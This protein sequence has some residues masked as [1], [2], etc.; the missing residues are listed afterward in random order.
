MI[1]GL[2]A[3]FCGWAVFYCL[4]AVAC[5]LNWIVI[6]RSM[7]ENVWKGFYCIWSIGG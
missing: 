1:W 3:V 6:L 7:L 5:M 4:L 2:V